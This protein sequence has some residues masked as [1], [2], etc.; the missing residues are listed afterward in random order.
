MGAKL[1]SAQRP[2]PPER[3]LMN[4]IVEVCGKMPRRKEG[5]RYIDN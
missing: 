2:R 4:G 1:P 3:K 5:Q